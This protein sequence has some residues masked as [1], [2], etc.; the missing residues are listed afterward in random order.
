VTRSAKG[1][2]AAA[3]FRRVVAYASRS[4]AQ[5]L[6][7]YLPER[8]GTAVPLVVYVHGGAF[9]GGDKA[10]HAAEVEALRGRGYAVASVNYRLSGEA[11]FPAG[12]QDVKAAVRWLRAA[13]PRYGLDPGR[14]GAWG[15]SAGGHLVAMLGATGDQPTVFD[16]PALGDP[17]VSSAVQAVVD[18]YGPTDF[19]LMDDQS[20]RTGCTAPQVHDEAGSPESRWLGA[21]IQTVPD[22]AHAA[23][24]ISYL[25]TARTL[26][27]FLV[28]H[29]DADCNVPHGQSELLVEALREHGGEVTF[30]LL[31]GVAHADPVFRE[32]Q[33]GPAI[34]FLDRVLGHRG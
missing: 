20:S 17:R 28:V 26:P 16:D 9:M 31:P 21:P 34:A 11:L 1:L 12:V 29:G 13:A 22:A 6:D 14:F 25:G 4:D 8:T 2:R 32:E 10:K 3:D 19:L 15:D 24:P 23:N 30:T 33:I 27:P 18:W 5:R 7:L